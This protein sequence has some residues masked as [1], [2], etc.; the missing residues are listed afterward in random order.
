MLNVIETKLALQT[1]CEKE[2]RK[3]KL[4]SQPWGILGQVPNM[5]KTDSGS[6]MPE[7]IDGNSGKISFCGQHFGIEA[8]DSRACVC[9]C[10]KQLVL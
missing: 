9:V 1:F 3:H 8:F 6:W 10:V 5:W 7:I 4:S 2:K